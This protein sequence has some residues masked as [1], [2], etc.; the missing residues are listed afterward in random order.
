MCIARSKG[1]GVVF[2]LFFFGR[3]RGRGRFRGG[4][5][6]EAWE[7]GGIEV[8]CGWDGMGWDGMGRR[9]ILKAWM[10]FLTVPLCYFHGSVGQKA[11]WLREDGARE[12]TGESSGGGGL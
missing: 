1:G 10:V 8:G 11:S 6:R 2:C 9:V 4:V 3:R 5:G 12:R 7:D